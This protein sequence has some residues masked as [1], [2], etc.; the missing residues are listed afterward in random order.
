MKIRPVFAMAAAAA[1]VFG[2]CSGAASPAPASQAPASVGA[3]TAPTSAASAAPSTAAA[4]PA[5]V[6]LQLQWVPQAQFAG[7]FAADKQGYYKAENLTVTMVPGG[8]LLVKVRLGAGEPSGTTVS[9]GAAMWM[10]LSTRTPM[11][12]V[13]TV[14]PAVMVK[15]MLYRADCV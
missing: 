1:V 8:S 7:Y 3:S 9:A 6:K 10:T 15:V 2:A 12:L 14:S 5:T 13:M 11:V 4:A